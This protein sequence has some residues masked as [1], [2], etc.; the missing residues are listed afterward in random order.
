MAY[1]VEVANNANGGARAAH[2][3]SSQLRI[4]AGVTALLRMSRPEICRQVL[5]I[6]RLA[7]A[8]GAN[9]LSGNLQ[10]LAGDQ[11]DRDAYALL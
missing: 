10:N 7:D 11:P 3:C 8:L 1:R 4:S 2:F 5:Y 6:P 9:C